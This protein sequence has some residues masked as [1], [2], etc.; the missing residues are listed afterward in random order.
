MTISEELFEKLCKNSQVGFEP[1]QTVTK[2]RTADYRIWLGNV[3][4]IAEVKQI[5]KGDYERRLLALAEDENAP[6]IPS[7]IHIRIRKKFQKAR[8]Q[9]KNLSHG[10]LPTLF[11][12]YDNTGGFS[13]MDNEAFLQAMHGNEIVE[14]YLAKND[15]RPK[16]VGSFHTFEKK[17]SKVRPNLSTSISCFCR[18]LSINDKPCLFLF[19]NEYAAVPLPTEAGKLIANRQFVRPS[20]KR[21][22]YRNWSLVKI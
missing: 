8:K 20:S 9:L 2:S 16:V 6:A 4:A 15:N 13:G 1:I 3:E 10:R 7:D 14:I 22:E 5:E 18:L 11:V 19:H 17:S 12:L 21:N